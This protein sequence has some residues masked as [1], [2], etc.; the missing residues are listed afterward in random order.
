MLIMAD[1]LAQPLFKTSIHFVIFFFLL[2]NQL[3]VHA[4]P[5]GLEHAQLACLLCEQL[6]HKCL[7]ERADPR[8]HAYMKLLIITSKC[9]YVFLSFIRHY[10]CICHTAS[11]AFQSLNLPMLSLQF[12]NTLMHIQVLA[13]FHLY[14]S[15][16]F[17]HTII[18]AKTNLVL[19]G[20]M[21]TIHFF[22]SS[23]SFN[24]LAWFC[25]P[26]VTLSVL[27]K[28]SH[29]HFSEIESFSLLHLCVVG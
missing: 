16:Y 29:P 21:H 1:L 6:D 18:H 19:D 5:A 9:A 15:T 2:A 7:A 11:V 22:F 28:P 4:P 23:L 3:E 24:S 14:A 10:L 27:A 17:A 26:S 13:F 25:S 12:A 8:R 20:L